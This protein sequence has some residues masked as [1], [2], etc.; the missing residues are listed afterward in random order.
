MS[1]PYSIPLCDDIAFDFSPSL[2]YMWLNYILLSCWSKLW[3]MDLVE[4]GL[5]PLLHTSS[6]SGHSAGIGPS[7]TVAILLSDSPIAWGADR[8]RPR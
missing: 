4:I 3:R 1:R 2:S 8:I 7:Q 5:R 6:R